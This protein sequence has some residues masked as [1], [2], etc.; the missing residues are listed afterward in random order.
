MACQARTSM[1]VRFLTRNGI[2]ETGA[3]AGQDNRQAFGNGT[4][5]AGRVGDFD[6]RPSILAVGLY[7]FFANM[8][9]RPKSFALTFVNFLSYDISRFRRN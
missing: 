4:V 3:T 6:E 2:R 7:K 1:R 5:F 8:G 9:F